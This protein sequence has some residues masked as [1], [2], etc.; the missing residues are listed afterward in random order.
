[1]FKKISIL[2]ID[3]SLHIGIL[4]PLWMLPGYL[5]F[6]ILFIYPIILFIE[7]KLFGFT[8]AELIVDQKFVIYPG[9]KNLFKRSIFVRPKVDKKIRLTLSFLLP[10]ISFFIF[11]LAEPLDTFSSSLSP[12]AQIALIEEL[13]CSV[14]QPAEGTIKKGVLKLPKN[15]GNLPYHLYKM[16]DKREKMTYYVQLSDMHSDWTH[17]PYSLVMKGAVYVVLDD[18]KL[19]VVKAKQSGTH[20]GHRSTT[21]HGEKNGES[22]LIRIVVLKKQIYKIEAVYPLNDGEKEAA[23]YEFINSFTPKA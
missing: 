5:P 18:A 1:M 4:S 15:S 3:L 7:R 11:I 22:H 19:D 6:L 13:N 9:L 8:L 12:T 21:I 14:I 10:I 23:A 17:Y 2:L 20:Q 16:E